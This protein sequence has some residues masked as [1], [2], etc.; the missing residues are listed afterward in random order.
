MRSVYDDWTL[1]LI[2][3]SLGFVKDE[4]SKVLFGRTI[5]GECGESACVCRQYLGSYQKSMMRLFY[6]KSLWLKTINYFNKKALL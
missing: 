3:S 5:Y 6:G 4:I 1:Q 2:K